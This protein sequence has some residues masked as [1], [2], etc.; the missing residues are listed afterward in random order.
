[1]EITLSPADI[2]VRLLCTL[3][4]GGAIGLNRGE[5]GRPAGL[6]TTML[7]ALAGCLTMLEVNLLLSTGG[8]GPG[9]F[10]TVDPMR[11]PLGLLT[12][13]GFIGGGAIVRRE[14][15]IVG[16]TTAA[17]LWY[18]TV[19]G[20]CFGAGQLLLGLTGSILGLLILM[21]LGRLEDRMPQERQATLMIV[22]TRSAPDAEWM[23]ARL[24]A[25][26]FRIN[27]LAAEFE[28]LSGTEKLNFELSWRAKAAAEGIPTSIRELAA[29]P[30]IALLSWTPLPR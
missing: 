6:R 26:G 7:V 9:S 8:K 22:I 3:A 23:R 11:L 30:G 19:L 16:V 4:M 18:V 24:V 12:G 15:M 20:L 5:H 29:A 28:Q 17:T 13:M 10:V 25:G 27:S 1:M 21:A 2:A 14:R